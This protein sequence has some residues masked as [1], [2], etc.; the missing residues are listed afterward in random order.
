MS[1][2]PVLYSAAQSARH[3]FLLYNNRWYPAA[4]RSPSRDYIHKQCRRSDLSTS[5]LSPVNAPAYPHPF[6]NERSESPRC[7]SF[8]C[9]RSKIQLR[10]ICT[11]CNGYLRKIRCYALPFSLPC[12]PGFLGSGLA[13]II[14]M[15]CGC[16]YG[17]T[18]GHRSNQCKCCESC[19]VMF[20]FHGLL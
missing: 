11:R 3:F 14:V 13:G 19:D 12:A 16:G 17:R 20:S 18:Y 15:L 10:L 6:Q 8:H 5:P 2:L 4:V 7:P 9:T 1:T